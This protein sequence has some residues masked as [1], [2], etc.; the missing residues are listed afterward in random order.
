MYINTEANRIDTSVAST[1]IKHLI[2]FTN[3]LD[4]GVFYSYA[5]HEAIYDRYTLLLFTYNVAPANVPY[6]G[7]TNLIPAGY[8]KYEAYEVS[9]IGTLGVALGTAPATETDTFTPADDDK[10]V[11][12]G[13]VAIGKL[14]LSEK[15]GDEQV[16]YVQNAKSVQTLTIQTGGA[17]YATAPTI[18]ITGDNITQ[19][20]ATC[21]ISGGVVNTVTIT[22]AGSGYTTNPTVKLAGGGF[23]TA[24]T[25]T[26]DINEENYIWYGQ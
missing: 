12:Q 24:A 21:T 14:N 19:A 7:Q 25:I 4:G 1:K 5:Q 20:T 22:N 6:G 18:I 13:L 11:V 17:G 16:Q 8:Y 2:K 9:W 26:A 23:T 15:A 3:D 10:G